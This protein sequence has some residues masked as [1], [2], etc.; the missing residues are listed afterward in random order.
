M[1]K[2]DERMIREATVPITEAREKVMRLRVEGAETPE[3][4]KSLTVVIRMLELA[5]SAM[6]LVPVSVT[7]K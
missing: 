2:I 4:D 5:E 6:G 1:T 3:Q 7:E